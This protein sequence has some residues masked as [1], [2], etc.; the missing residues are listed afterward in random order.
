MGS[1]AQKEKVFYHSLSSYKVKRVILA[2]K[3]SVEHEYAL[4]HDSPKL[5]LLVFSVKR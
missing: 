1:P 5:V 4:F 2:V 3:W